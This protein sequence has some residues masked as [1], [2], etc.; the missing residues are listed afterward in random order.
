[1][2]NY[3][4]RVLKPIAKKAEIPDMTFQAMRRTFATHFQR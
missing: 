1:V 4:K 2:D 3:L